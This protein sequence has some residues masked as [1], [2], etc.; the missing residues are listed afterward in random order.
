MDSPPEKATDE[1]RKRIIPEISS[2]KP[3]I[4]NIVTCKMLSNDFDELWAEAVD[5]R[6]HI[7]CIASVLA[8]VGVSWRERLMGGSETKKTSWLAGE[9]PSTTAREA[10]ASPNVY[11]T[12]NEGCKILS[13]FD[14][15][16]DSDAAIDY[17]S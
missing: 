5:T 17:P 6:W 9:H 1:N 10:L 14:S 13:T 12:Y 11:V 7:R 3:K 15:L 4:E 8:A 2:T 16:L